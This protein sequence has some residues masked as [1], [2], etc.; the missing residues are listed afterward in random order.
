M[1]T[2]AVQNSVTGK[3]HHCDGELSAHC[4]ALASWR[5]GHWLTPALATSAPNT[6]TRLLATPAADS[7]TVPLQPAQV[8]ALREQAYMLFY[9]VRGTEG[10]AVAEY[11][12]AARQAE[13]EG[14]E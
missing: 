2:A 7:H 4:W 12:L 9:R 5:A 8:A 6:H 3:W 11:N 14:G 13:G 10:K 1:F